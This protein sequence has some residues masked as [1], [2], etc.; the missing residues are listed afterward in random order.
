MRPQQ[1][2]VVQ[3]E[4]GK[5]AGRHTKFYEKCEAFKKA[6]YTAIMEEG[7]KGEIEQQILARDGLK[8]DDCVYPQNKYSCSSLKYDQLPSLLLN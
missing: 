4:E 3:K 8:I 7:K 6:V 1:S 5:K 2:V